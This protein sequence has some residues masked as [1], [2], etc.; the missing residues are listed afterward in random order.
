MNLIR[1]IQLPNGRLTKNLG[2]GCAGILRLPTNGQRENLLRTA[3]DS[4]ITHFD[5]ARMYGI[6]AAEGMLGSCLKKER[7]EITL[8]TKFGFPC[9]VPNRR[10]VFVQSVGR[11]AVNLHP[12]LKKRM[13]NRAAAGGADRHYNYSVEEME[14]SLETSLRE[15]KTDSIDLYFIHEPRRADV[16]PEGLGSA[17]RQKKAAGT[18]GA[19]GISGVP[20]DLLYF[21]KNRPELCGEAIQHNFFLDEARNRVVEES[22]YTG[23][24]HVLSGCLTGMERFLGRDRALAGLWSDKMSLDI[25]QRE[26]LAAVILAMALSENPKR[27]VLFFTSN[28]R[29]IRR[30]VEIL[31]HNSFSPEVLSE[32]RGVLAQQAKEL[33]AL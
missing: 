4:G 27:M 31:T 1:E 5:V 14:G 8:A 9:G 11:W 6:G 30:M 33:Y 23:V 7:A 15:L 12:G 24:F 18:V 21:L 13:K 28:S 3:F 20:S 16:V 25:S 29:R 2:F 19:F 26:N 17:L 32:F 10:T 22:A